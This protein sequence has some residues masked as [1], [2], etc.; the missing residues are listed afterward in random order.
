MRCGVVLI[1]LLL[2]FTELMVHSICV[3]VQPFFVLCLG[4]I[5][6]DVHSC[7]RYPV[8]AYTLRAV[9]VLFVPIFWTKVPLLILVFE[10]CVVLHILHASIL[11]DHYNG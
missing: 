8:E 11:V 6:F 1:D 2:G 9:R 7:S 4:G 3:I 10:S 5:L